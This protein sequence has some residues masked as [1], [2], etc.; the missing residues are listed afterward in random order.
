MPK[1]DV[2][3]IVNEWKQDLKTQVNPYMKLSIIQIGD[4][5]ASNIY[6]KGKKERL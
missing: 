6:I 3:Q 4:D 5:L 1:I 2:K